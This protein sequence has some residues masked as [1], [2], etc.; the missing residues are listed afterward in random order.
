MC[1]FFFVTAR[2]ARC[3][4]NGNDYFV[5]AT[6]LLNKGMYLEALGMYEEI[7]RYSDDSNN[8]AWALLFMGTTH[9]LYL[10][11]Y[12][13]ALQQFENVIKVYPDSPAAPEALFNGGVVFYKKGEFKRAYEIFTYYVSLYPQG[14][15]KESAELWAESSKTQMA[16]TLKKTLPP[17]ERVIEDTIIRVLIYNNGNR[18]TVNSEKT[19]TV[20]QSFSRKTVYHGPGP[21][22][23]AKKENI[24]RSMEGGLI[25]VY[26]A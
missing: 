14:I 22:T 23:F 16:A 24:L 11:Q 18:V 9:S 3:S 8:K 10:D 6:D 7:A 12:D 17:R 13:S 19:I 2:T 4:Y 20:Y 5:I 26:A 1:L 15:R 25:H 21:L